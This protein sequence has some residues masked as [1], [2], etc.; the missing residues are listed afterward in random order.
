MGPPESPAGC[1]GAVG[2]EKGAAAPG[3]ESDQDPMWHVKAIGWW[4][5]LVV[6]APSGVGA[7]CYHL[8]NT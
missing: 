8:T 2:A 6:L 7:G 3:D 1:F 4:L 5:L